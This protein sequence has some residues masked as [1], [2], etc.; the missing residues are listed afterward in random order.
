M[1]PA[2]SSPLAVRAGWS[3]RTCPLE[4]R[5]VRHDPGGQPPAGCLSTPRQ[6][7]AHDRYC[8]LNEKTERGGR[9]G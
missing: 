5:A 8:Q 1:M 7:S 9:D 4:I 2:P 6:P 3:W